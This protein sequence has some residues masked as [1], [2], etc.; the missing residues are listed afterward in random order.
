MD[1]DNIGKRILKIRQQTGFSQAKFARFTDVIYSYLAMVEL[2]KKKPSFNFIVSVLDTTKV[3][4]DWLL[5]G[6]G[7]MYLQTKE[8]KQEIKEINEDRVAYGAD[9]LSR[10]DDL[11]NHWDKLNED[12]KRI[13]A[14]HAKEMVENNLMREFI[15]KMTT[16]RT[17][18]TLQVP[19]SLET[20]SD[21]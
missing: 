11:K 4:A 20:S 13:L 6:E 15:N 9:N 21:N 8:K 2:G 17:A 3:S 18:E 1:I 14:G 10:P 12:Q 16:S 5:T 19:S 7:A